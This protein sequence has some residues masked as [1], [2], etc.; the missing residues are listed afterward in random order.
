MELTEAINSMYT[1]YRSATVCYVYMRDVKGSGHAKTRTLSGFPQS[2]W[3]TRGWTLQ[4]LLAP[5]KVVFCDK[6]W[7][8]FGTKTNLAT[9][10]RKISGIPEPFLEGPRQPQEASVAMRMIWISR[11]TTTQPEDIAYCVVGLFNVNMPLLYGEGEKA[12]TRL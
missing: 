11:R 7:Q 5:S 1:W 9:Q 4:E 8:V 10:I 2:D 6:H 12:F 3:F